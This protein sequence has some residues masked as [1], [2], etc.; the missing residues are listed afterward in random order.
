V[1]TSVIFGLL[2]GEVIP[3]AALQRLSDRMPALIETPAISPTLM[4]IA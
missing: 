3:I 1:K 2:A 4:L